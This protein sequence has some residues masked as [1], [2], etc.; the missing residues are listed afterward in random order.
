MFSSLLSVSGPFFQFESDIQGRILP[1]GQ[2]RSCMLVCIHV[3]RVRYVHV[4]HGCER[5]R[6]CKYVFLKHWQDLI[7][8]DACHI[9]S[10]AHV[11][12]DDFN[13]G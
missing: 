3:K 13:L 12:D 9:C 5:V 2:I 11:I 8:S 7:T 6:F 10:P 1:L 4:V